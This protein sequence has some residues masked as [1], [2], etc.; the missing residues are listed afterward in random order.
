MR[1]TSQV[2]PSSVVSCV[3]SQT[4]KLGW[5]PTYMYAW[6]GQSA[7]CSG[8]APIL[9][10]IASD[11]ISVI[12]HVILTI[13][14]ARWRRLPPQTFSFVNLWV[15]FLIG[16]AKPIGE[17]VLLNLSAPAPFAFM[18]PLLR[19]NGFAVAAA[20]SGAFGSRGW[21]VQYLAIDSF[22]TLATF[23][24][25][26][27]RA[28]D[29]WNGRVVVPREAVPG[30]PPALQVM[31]NGM[32]VA[33]LPGALFACAYVLS[34]LW[35]M[36]LVVAAVTKKWAFAR[37]AFKIWLTWACFFLVVLTS[38]FLAVW[39]LVWK[40][41]HRH[42]AKAGERFPAVRWYAAWFTGEKGDLLKLVGILGYWAWVA[43]Q[44]SVFV[45]RWMVLAN[46]LP[47]AGDAW[48]PASLKEIEAGS[49]LST[50]L[51]LGGLLGLKAFNLTV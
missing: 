43:V 12:A 37:L 46:L 19:P 4:S 22:G 9:I 28:P 26:N 40:R 14:V 49:A 13:L 2:P 32:F 3:S 18:L 41:L 44:F 27:L 29:F 11:V 47:L 33:T 35:P 21:G 51:M 24:L 6:S 50:I 20:V 23:L 31:Y 16:F 42:E 5:L 10:S 48:C 25:F 7:S 34:G 17:G 36:L 45:G 8:A 1:C 38:P 30:A 39:E 15:S